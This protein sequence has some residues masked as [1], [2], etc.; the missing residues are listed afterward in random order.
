M[1]HGYLRAVLRF[2]YWLIR[3]GAVKGIVL[4]LRRSYPSQN[5]A[6]FVAPFAHNTNAHDM[7]SIL[8]EAKIRPSWTS[9]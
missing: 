9:K 4:I 6:V 7:A 5:Q 1:C 8:T 3:D 2:C